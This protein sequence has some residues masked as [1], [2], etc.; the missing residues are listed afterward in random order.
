VLTGEL[1]WQEALKNNRVEVLRKKG[2]RERYPKS[3]MQSHQIENTVLS[4][5]S[6]AFWLP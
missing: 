4:H 1:Q 6:R 3:A 2:G 5:P